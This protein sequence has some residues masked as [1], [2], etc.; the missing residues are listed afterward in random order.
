MYLS[1]SQQEK[2]KQIQLRIAR[3]FDRVCS[4]NDIEYFII[5]GTLLGAVRHKGFIPWDDDL[6]VGMTRENFDRF[7]EIAASRLDSNFVF[8]TWGASG[9]LGLPY[10]KLRM[11]NTKFVERASKKSSGPQGV[12]I[13]IF[14]FDNVP[15]SQILQ[16]VQS[17]AAYVLK[18]LIVTKYGYDM[19]TMSGAPKKLIYGLITALASVIPLKHINHWLD[20]EIRRYNATPTSRMTAFGGS[21]GYYKEAIQSSWSREL[22]RITF[23]DLKLP[24]F[25]RYDDYLTS[26]YGNY[27]VPPPVESRV[28][29]HDLI[30]LIL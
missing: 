5:A 17:G 20:R 14:P 26:L 6:D 19:T 2:L 11:K 7:A 28:S 24:A 3:E 30:E 18:R 10:A 25:K 27:M 4:E 16:R 9:G 22:E 8:Q 15:H 13:D 23:G 12:Y 1:R 21:Y 29:R